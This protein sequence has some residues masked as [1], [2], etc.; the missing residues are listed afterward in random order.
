[1]ASGA[2]GPTTDSSFKQALLGE[3]STQLGGTFSFLGNYPD[4]DKIIIGVIAT[5]SGSGLSW[6]NVSVKHQ[7]VP[8][9]SGF[10]LSFEQHPVVIAAR[11]NVVINQGNLSQGRLAQSLLGCMGAYLIR[12]LQQGVKS[13]GLVQ[14]NYKAYCE[15]IGLLVDPGQSITALFT[16]DPDGLRRGL[17]AGLCILDANYKTYMSKY[18]GDKNAAMQKTIRSHLGDPNSTD[19]VTG[20]S[21]NDYL[22]RVMNNANA[23][24]NSSGASRYS[25]MATGAIK[26]AVNTGSSPG[27][28]PGCGVL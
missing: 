14:N 11:K 26:Q 25:S 9:T 5:E 16:E 17:V 7:I 21:S 3:I 28:T 24:S 4:V 2:A 19:V 27:T 20:I 10:G 8:A 15:S 23:F 13:F 1:M 6:S 22:A 18:S 12:G